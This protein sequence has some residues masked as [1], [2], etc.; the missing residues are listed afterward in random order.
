[1]VLYIF[2]WVPKRSNKINITRQECE[3]KSSTGLFNQQEENI[4]VVVTLKACVLIEMIRD[5]KATVAI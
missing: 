1:M 2:I 5:V 3:D 4:Q